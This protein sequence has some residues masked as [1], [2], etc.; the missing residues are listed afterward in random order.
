MLLR[1][2]HIHTTRLKTAVNSEGVSFEQHVKAEIR[3]TTFFGECIEGKFW[4]DLEGELGMVCADLQD[5][6]EPPEEPNVEYD[7]ELPKIVLQIIGDNPAQTGPGLD[8]LES[9]WLACDT[10]PLRQVYGL[11][12]ESR[13]SAKLKK[14]QIERFM[15]ALLRYFAARNDVGSWE[16]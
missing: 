7:A 1:F 11:L 13:E 3:R 2:S 12:L 9:N 16:E 10:L 4:T 6:A 5:L 15:W 8:L 14:Q